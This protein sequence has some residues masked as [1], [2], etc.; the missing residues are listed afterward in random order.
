MEEDGLFP[1]GELA[2]AK[3]GSCLLVHMLDHAIGL[4]LSVVA[5]VVIHLGQ[6]YVQLDILWRMFFVGMV[7][8][9]FRT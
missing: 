5:V 4:K 3:F 9:T 8:R 7:N 1:V 6:I 2:F